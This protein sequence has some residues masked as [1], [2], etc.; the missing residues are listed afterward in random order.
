MRSTLDEDLP[1][2]IPLARELGLLDLY[3]H[4]QRVRFEDWLRID[5]EIAGDVRDLLVPSLVLQPLVE[6][7]IEHGAQ[8]EAGRAHVVIRARREGGELILEVENLRDPGGSAAAARDGTGL[9]NTRSRL[10]HLHPGRH[11]MD[12]GPVASRGWLAR[13]RIPATPAPAENGGDA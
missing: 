5:Q 3:L 1:H 11:A 6:N 7:A 9:R 2:E 13:I 4:I 8:D 10:Q 12:A